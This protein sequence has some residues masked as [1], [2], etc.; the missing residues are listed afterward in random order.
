MIRM[1]AAKI[2]I[3]HAGN[4]TGAGI[5][6]APVSFRYLPS[7]ARWSD[8]LLANTRNARLP[9]RT[10]LTAPAAVVSVGDWV[11]FAPR[12]RVAVAIE[13]ASV[14]CVAARAGGADAASVR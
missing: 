2:T 5:I 9:I 3:D 7:L 11:G 6:P 8:R 1:N 4:E 14:A 13:K 12:V 10:S